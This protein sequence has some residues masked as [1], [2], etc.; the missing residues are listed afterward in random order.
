MQQHTDTCPHLS[1]VL[2]EMDIA[3]LVAGEY[4]ITVEEATKFI[5]HDH[6]IFLDV[7]THEEAKTLTFSFAKHILRN[8]LPYR[9]VEVPHNKFIITF[10]LSGFRA[11]MAYTYLRAQGY[12]EIKALKGRLDQL[13]GAMTPGQFYQL[14]P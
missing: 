9:L 11:S 12:D 8:E 5:N 7:R 14:H 3:F 1:E 10:C 6:F 13:A 4:G 2:R